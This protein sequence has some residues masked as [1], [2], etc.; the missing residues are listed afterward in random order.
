MAIR[1]Q[2]SKKKGQIA[3]ALGHPIF[4]VSR[5]NGI[6]SYVVAPSV[7]WILCG[8]SVNKIKKD[9]FSIDLHKNS[10]NKSCPF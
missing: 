5:G 7:T 1:V 10:I 3:Y 8:C 2:P 4:Q 9:Q 6:Q